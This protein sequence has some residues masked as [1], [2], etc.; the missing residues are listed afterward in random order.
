MKFSTQCSITL[1]CVCLAPL[2]QANSLSPSSESLLQNKL[3]V[4][5]FNSADFYSQ[6]AQDKFVYALLYGLL[7]KQDDGYYLE[8]GSGEPIDINNSYFLE[9]T[10]GWKGLSI[11]IC[12]QFYNPWISCRNNPLIITDAL[13]CD[14]ISLLEA[15]PPVI[16]YL[17]LDIDANYDKILEKLPF[18]KY[19]FKIITIEHDAYHYGDVYKDRERAIL[20]SFGYYLLCPEVS[21][22]G[23]FEDWWVHPSAFPSSVLSEMSALGLEKKEHP[24][25]ISI[26]QDY[27]F[28]RP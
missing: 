13:E 18:D 19:T 17:S 26:I 12:H 21:N 28:N 5:D 3:T 27:I 25:L 6:A 10:L 16:D 14:Y 9:K 24:E 8:I 23:P 22:G 11:D 15:F 1:A 20:Q 4:T 2:I 7:G